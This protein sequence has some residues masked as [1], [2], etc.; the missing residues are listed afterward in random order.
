MSVC[1]CVHM[2]ACVCVCVHMYVC[3]SVCELGE[4][5]TPVVC[6]NMDQLTCDLPDMCLENS[7]T[8]RERAVR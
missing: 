3:V 7:A 2:Y 8:L 5:N 4:M 1:V 6:F